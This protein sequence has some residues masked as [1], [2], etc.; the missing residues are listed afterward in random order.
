MIAYCPDTGLC[1][2]AVNLSKNADLL[3]AECALKSGEDLPDWPHLNPVT[4]AQL[5]KEAQ[6]KQLAL[7]HFD[8]ERY[9]TLS[10]RQEAQKEA[11]KIYPNVISAHDDMHIPL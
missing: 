6:V 1:E 5:A 7:I 4:A 3:I 9:P 8:A 11:Q 10:E 2:N